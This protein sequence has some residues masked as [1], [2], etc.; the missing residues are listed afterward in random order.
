MLAAEGGGEEGE[1]LDKERVAKTS[2]KPSMTA[3]NNGELHPSRQR[4]VFADPAAF[5]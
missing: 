1:T 3:I 2:L 5:R 4:L